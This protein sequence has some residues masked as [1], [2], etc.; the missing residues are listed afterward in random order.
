MNKY[1]LSP[2]T[3]Q[4]YA[5]FSIGGAVSVNAHGITT[6]YAMDESVLALKIV[7]WDGSLVECSREGS[8]TY[9]NQFIY[10]FCDC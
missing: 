7:K 9:S 2:R 3:M 1:G 5:S 8:H 6:D 4:S 10:Y